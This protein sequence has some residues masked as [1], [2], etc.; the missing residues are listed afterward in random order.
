ML[1]WAFI[2]N[3][4]LYFTAKWVVLILLYAIFAILRTGQH[5]IY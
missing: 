1:E 2:P 5:Y 4:H 3:H